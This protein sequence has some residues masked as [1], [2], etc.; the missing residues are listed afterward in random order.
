[1]GMIIYPCPN[2]D[3]GLA[4][5]SSN[6]SPWPILCYY[7]Q[8]SLVQHLSSCHSSLYKSPCSSYSHTSSVAQYFMN[9]LFLLI[10]RGP[11]TKY[12]ISSDPI[13]PYWC[14]LC[15]REISVGKQE[16]GIQTGGPDA[17]QD[18]VT[19]FLIVEYILNLI[20]AQGSRL[21]GSCCGLMILDITHI[22]QDFFTGTL[23]VIL[24]QCQWNHPDGYG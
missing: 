1:M 7:T 17:L 14:S 3:T 8:S 12:L 16:Y 2:P 21:V 18:P 24:P 4:N 6:R 22:P 19:R 10:A 23:T 11:K 9:L 20:Y 5:L 15:E 13:L